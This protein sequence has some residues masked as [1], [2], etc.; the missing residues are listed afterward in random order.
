MPGLSP[1]RPVG[2]LAS[3]GL[4]P[5]GPLLALHGEQLM[6]KLRSPSLGRDQG[7]LPLALLP[8]QAP[9]LPPGHGPSDVPRELDLLGRMGLLAGR[10]PPGFLQAHA[11]LRPPGGRQPSRGSPLP[12]LG[13]R[14]F[15]VDRGQCPPPRGPAPQ[16]LLPALLSAVVVAGH[17]LVA[18]LEVLWAS[19]NI[20]A[21]LSMCV[22]GARASLAQPLL[23]DPPGL[24]ADAW[25]PARD[26]HGRQGLDCLG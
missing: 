13:G 17:P 3:G 5:P 8:P 15:R 14:H 2:R 22:A 10:P 6:V 18:P 25:H 1:Y 20:R 9:G 26:R 19:P 11:C 23:R 24:S 7:C 4:L 21:S 16:E 12:R